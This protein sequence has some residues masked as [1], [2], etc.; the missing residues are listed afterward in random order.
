MGLLQVFI[1]LCTY[2]AT[3][4]FVV[5]DCLVWW[6]LSVLE[7]LVLCC[8]AWPLASTVADR[9]AVVQCSA[10]PSCTEGWA[11][12]LC[13][14]QCSAWSSFACIVV[15]V[16]CCSAWSGTF[17]LSSSSSIVQWSEGVWGTGTAGV[18]S[19]LLPPGSLFCCSDWSSTGVPFL[20]CCSARSS[21]A[22][23]PRC[24]QV[25]IWSKLFITGV[26]T[27]LVTAH[28]IVWGCLMVWVVLELLE[29]GLWLLS[30]SA[31]PLLLSLGP[32]WAV[33]SSCAAWLSS[34]KQVG[35][36]L[37]CS[38]WLAS[39][40]LSTGTAGVVSSLLPPRQYVTVFTF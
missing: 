35:L 31:R 38:A 37:L 27:Y 36:T 3:A 4:H 12:I 34:W 16:G 32:T 14:G 33:G 1:G 40:L 30:C 24:W 11:S 6:V 29:L 9:V 17:G 10:R 20:C 19:S 21:A 18:V 5:W 2:L 23:F 13:G 39:P 26:D 8:S 7:L 15:A 22:V 25:K 28:G